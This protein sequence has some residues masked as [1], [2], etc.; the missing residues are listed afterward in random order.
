MEDKE[1][2]NFKSG[3]SFISISL[4]TRT[5]FANRLACDIPVGWA[6]RA[7]ETVLLFAAEDINLV[8]QVTERTEF[9][10]E[11]GP[12]LSQMKGVHTAAKHAKTHATRH[13]AVSIDLGS[14]GMAGNLLK[15]TWLAFLW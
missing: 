12:L 14:V 10:E 7:V 6:W 5:S 8:L 3:W 13:I 11:P 9:A 4:P 1:G 15:E 2:I